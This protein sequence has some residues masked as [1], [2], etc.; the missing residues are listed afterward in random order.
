M[1]R[2]LPLCTL[3]L[4]CASVTVGCGKKD[5]PE[6]EGGGSSG[7]GSRSSGQ[8]VL[9]AMNADAKKQAANRLKQIGLALHNYEGSNGY[10]PAGIVG[11]KGQLGLSWRV[12]I[13]PYVEE[14]K[15]YQEFKLDEP[16]DSEHNKKLIPRMPKIYEPPNV[17]LANGKTFLRSFSGP[18]AV[19]PGAPDG[20]KGSTFS[21][22]ANQPAGTPAR[23]RGLIE[24]SDGTSN[25]LMVVEA[26]EPVEWTKPEDL[27]FL[28]APRFGASGPP[29]GPLPRLGGLFDGGFHALYGDG[30][31]RFISDR[32]N[33]QNLRALITVNGGEVVNWDGDETAAPARPP[34]FESRPPTRR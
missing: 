18:Q 34:R 1:S 10:F 23:G 17:I 14:G 26:F 6:P 13:L 22:W 19:I 29:P 33:E 5:D 27:A 20:P 3:V 21:R 4:L 9:G 15:L 32:M 2:V 25:T 30:S 31:V 7:G 11:P 28:D 8:P 12:A 16:W 24:F